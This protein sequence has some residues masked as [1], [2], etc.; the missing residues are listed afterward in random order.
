VAAE[1]ANNPADGPAIDRPCRARQLRAVTPSPR[2]RRS[3]ILFVTGNRLGD[4]VLSTGALARL[5]AD[6]PGARVTVACGALPAPLFADVPGLARLIVMRRRRRGMHWLILWA[7]CAATWWDVA[8]DL[9][10]SILPWTLPAR[11]RM[12][13]RSDYRRELRVL[14]I[15]RQLRL[16]P[17]PAPTLFISPTRA[18]RAAAFVGDGPPVLAVAPAANWGAKQWPAE[19]FAET[20]RRLTAPGEILEGARIAVTAAESERAAAAPVLESVPPARRI[21][22]VGAPDLLDLAAILARCALFIGNDSGLMHLAAAAGTPTLGLFGPSPDW[23]YGPWGPKAAV[24]RTKE[25]FESLVSENP[26]FD[27]RRG[28]SLMAG[29]SVDAVVEAAEALLRK[30]AAPALS[31]GSGAAP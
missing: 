30:V 5:I 9:R 16:D 1:R 11:R 8:A 3:N 21:D 19:R 15:A 6:H 20:V 18:A 26:A 10:G 2:A 31:A 7:A 25:S 17:P 13:S 27:F 23:R 22:L 28:E 14:E 12:V 24:V 4:A 29:L